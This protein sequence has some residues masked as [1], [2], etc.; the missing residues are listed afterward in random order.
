MALFECDF[1]SA[2]K[3]QNSIDFS[4]WQGGSE[5]N[6]GRFGPDSVH[7]F[8]GVCV[9]WAKFRWKIVSVILG[10]LVLLLE[11]PVLEL[12]LVLTF[13]VN[14]IAVRR[15]LNFLLLLAEV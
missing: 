8:S 10:C 7:E 15:N 11:R 1:Y 5:D 4:V 6:F 12:G 9:P 2:I 14:F 13:D 3:H